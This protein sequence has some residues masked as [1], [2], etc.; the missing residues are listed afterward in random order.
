LLLH[1]SLPEFS[2][3]TEPARSPLRVPFVNVLCCA[4][5]RQNLA[6]TH[7]SLH[8]GDSVR[9]QCYFH[10]LDETRQHACLW[11]LCKNS[12]MAFTEGNHILPAP[13]FL[14]RLAIACQDMGW[15][16]RPF[17]VFFTPQRFDT[18]KV[19]NGPGP[20]A[21]AATQQSP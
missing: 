3:K 6:R 17:Y 11:W 4:R 8:C 21:P 14:N 20:R 1:P 16:R 19:H 5:S 2:R 18:A 7:R 10:R 12:E 15:K 9:L 13:R